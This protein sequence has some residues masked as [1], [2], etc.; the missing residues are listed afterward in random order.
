MLGLGLGVSTEEIRDHEHFG[1]ADGGLEDGQALSSQIDHDLKG[2]ED[3][4]DNA[5]DELDLHRA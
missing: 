4:D 2:V 1:E 5:D 3:H